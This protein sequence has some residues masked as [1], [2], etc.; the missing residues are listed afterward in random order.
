MTHLYLIRHGQAMCNVP[1]FLKVAGMRGDDGLTALGIAQAERLRDRLAATGEIAADVVIASTLPRARQTAEIVAPALGRPLLFDDEV[2]ELRV[3]EADGMLTEDFYATYGKPD[4]RR[5]PYRPLSPGGENWP[6]FLARVGAALHRIVRE[7][8]DKT[9]V[10]V[11]HGGVIDATFSIFFNL[12]I[13]PSPHLQMHTRNTSITHW[14]RIQSDGEPSHWHL[15]RYNDAL[16]TRDID[17]VER[18]RWAR[19]V[20]SPVL[21]ADEPAAPLPTEE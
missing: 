9:V 14:E 1:P 19:L 10:V 6:L 13:E 16:H 18:I 12:G 17:A 20:A 4:L 3:G 15:H 7:H 8:A 21:D 11:C 2:Q 5:D